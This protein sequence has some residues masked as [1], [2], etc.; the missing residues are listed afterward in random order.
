MTQTSNQRKSA[1]RVP[2]CLDLISLLPV[3]LFKA[4]GD[5]NRIGML[6]DLTAGGTT[7]SV[8]QVAE[9]CPVHISVVSR[10]LKILKRAGILGSEKRGKEVQYHVRIP[11][12]VGLLRQLADALEACCTSEVC[13]IP[14]AES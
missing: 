13:T 1:A 5:V 7:Q 3:E 9:R 11:Y 4:L 2:K 6:A 8:S 14:D 12:L 10:H